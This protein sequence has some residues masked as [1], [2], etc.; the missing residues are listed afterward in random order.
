MYRC[1]GRL[2][3][4]VLK[5]SPVSKGFSSWL[6]VDQDVELLAPSAPCL[7]AVCHASHHDDDG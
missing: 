2:W 4:P 7:S 3:G 6:P 5:L 1:G